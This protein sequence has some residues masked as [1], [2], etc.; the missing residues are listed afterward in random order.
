MHRILLNEFTAEYFTTTRNFLVY[1]RV[2]K[3]SPQQTGEM[4]TTGERWQ[5]RAI[6]K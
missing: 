1:P 2:E 6:K 5:E 3:H 4:T